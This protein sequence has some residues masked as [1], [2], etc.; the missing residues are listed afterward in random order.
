[1]PYLGNTPSTSF[2]TIVK[3]TFNGGSTGYTLSKVATTNSVSV[4][5]ENVRQEPTTAY[6]VSGTTLTFTATTPSGTGNIYVLHMNPTTTTTHPAAQNLTAVDGT[7]TGDVSVGD[8]LSLA[9][10]SAVLSFGADSD[11]TITHDPDDG[12]IFK[13]TATADDNPL[14]LTLQTG[15]TDLAANDVIGKIAFQAPDEGTGTDAVLVSAAIQAVA[16]GD[17]SASSNATSLQFMTGAS[18]AAA[19][20]MRIDSSGNVAIGNTSPSSQYMTRLVVGDGSGTEGI[21]I[22]SGND[23]SGRLE[24]SDATSG[25]GRYAG[26]IVYEHNNNALR[27]NTNGGNERMRID[28]DGHVTMPN[29]SCFQARPS[30]VISNI[31]TASSQTLSFATEVFD[32]NAD[33]NTSNYNFVAP[34]TGK[35]LLTLNLRVQAL[36]I[37]G[38]YFQAL[39]L[40]SNKEYQSIISTN[41]F[42]ADP[43]YWY[44][45]V[46]VVADMDASDTAIPRVYISSDSAAQVDI[47]N[48][49]YFSGY[50]V[51]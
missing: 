48:D 4:F 9:S 29:Q 50:L 20:K 34:V 38:S 41:R 33:Y 1:M 40:T 23:S 19:E 11:V 31:T 26:G 3:D 14:L 18:E 17:H 45:G 39:I 6:S 28:A 47:D 12:L 51:A 13:S 21:T 24:F 42:S 25:D 46:T 44:I 22:Y 37:S 32:L 8:D 7:F 5:V 27:F 10:D 43:A 35:Y 16:E 36:D 15:E 2:A 30:G 49:S